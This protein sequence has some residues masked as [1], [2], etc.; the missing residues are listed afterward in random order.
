[1]QEIERERESFDLV[2]DRTARWDRHVLDW[3]D[4]LM[5]YDMLRWHGPSTILSPLRYDSSWYG[6]RA[7][8]KWR[9]AMMRLLQVELALQAFRIDAGRDP[10]ALAQLVPTYLS[11][12]PLAPY[13]NGRIRYRR[14]DG[15]YDC[16]SIGPDNKDDGGERV[17]QSEV[18]FKGDLFL[19]TADFNDE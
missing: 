3:D 12:V 17:P 18:Q 5:N 13:D 10:M 2:L 14:T 8:E 19:D 16:Y 6:G 9:D 11:S 7:S 1:M 4:W 15:G